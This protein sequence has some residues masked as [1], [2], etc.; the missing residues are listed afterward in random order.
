[1]L[2]YRGNFTS[3]L[4]I[5]D[6]AEL[7]TRTLFYDL[8]S[9]SRREVELEFLLNFLLRL[10]REAHCQALIPVVYQESR[11]AQSWLNEKT[12]N[13][14][15][16]GSTKSKQ[17]F[18]LNLEKCKFQRRRKHVGKISDIF[19]VTTRLLNALMRLK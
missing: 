1:M 8:H 15:F 6:N 7:I 18:A 5:C 4:S 13:F 16:R 14:D 9:S 3:I 17:N 19:I 12:L 11:E 10:S 2:L